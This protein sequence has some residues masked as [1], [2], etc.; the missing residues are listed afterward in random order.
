MKT[1]YISNSGQVLL[2]ENNTPE[3]AYRQSGGIDDIYYLKEDTNVVYTKGEDK[4][5]LEGKAG[6]L[7]I[8]FYDRDF[9]NK[10]ILVS[11]KEWAENMEAREAAEQKR[12]ED[13][14]K[15]QAVNEDLPTCDCCGCDK[16]CLNDSF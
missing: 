15:K 10:V 12:K 5:T 3:P 4:I 6:D 13:W 14:A 9:T 7:V 2:N 8:I 1:L 11:S 16:H